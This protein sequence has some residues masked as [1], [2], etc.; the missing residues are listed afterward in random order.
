M[1]VLIRV[2]NRLIKSITAKPTKNPLFGGF[3]YALFSASIIIALVADKFRNK[4]F[5]GSNDLLIILRIRH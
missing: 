2:T 3:F 1:T 4:L 5:D